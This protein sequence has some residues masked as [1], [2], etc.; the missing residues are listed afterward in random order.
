MKI[1]DNSNLNPIYNHKKTIEKSLN[2]VG[3]GKKEVMS[4]ASLKML[5]DSLSSQISETSQQITNSNNSIAM[6]QIASSSLESLSKMGDEL[7]QLSV[8]YNNAA[9]NSDQKS[10][11]ANQ[12][13]ALKRSMSDITDSTTFNGKNLFRSGA[14][15]TLGVDLSNVSVSN[16]SIEKELSLEDVLSSLDV[17]TDLSNLTINSGDTLQDVLNNLSIDLNDIKAYNA[18]DKYDIVGAFEKL[19]VDFSGLDIDSIEIELNDSVSDVLSKLNINPSSI[20]VSNIKPQT[21]DTI[22][23]FMTNIQSALSAI[24]G[25]TNREI[26]NINYL[27][28]KLVNHS[29]SRSINA[30]TDIAQNMI[31]IAND[32]IKLNA[33]LISQ[34][35]QQSVLANS[36]NNLL[37]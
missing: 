5:I 6:L 37:S 10:M 20:D 26:S 25:A 7:N 16:L 9:L 34:A 12:F 22:N 24:S 32:D 30:D 13:E 23:E 3:S 2:E 18:V 31:N 11:I 15:E 36:L 14:F 21:K 28:E 35:H 27:S 1:T 33:S 17:D 8:Q 19:G 4:E 29:N